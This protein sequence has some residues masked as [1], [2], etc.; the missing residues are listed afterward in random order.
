M[1]S[2]YDTNILNYFLFIILRDLIVVLDEELNITYNYNCFCFK[3]TFY[4]FLNSFNVLM[5]KIKF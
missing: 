1:S 5:L 4:V 3:L 2:N